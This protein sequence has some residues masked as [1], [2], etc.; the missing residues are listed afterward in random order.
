VKANRGLAPTT[1]LEYLFAKV[2]DFSV[3]AAPSD[4]RTALVLRYTGA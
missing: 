2:A 1:L 4:D 3:G